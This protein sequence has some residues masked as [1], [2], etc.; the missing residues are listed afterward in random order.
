MKVHVLLENK[1][2]MKAYRNV[3][4]MVTHLHEIIEELVTDL[5]VVQEGQGIVSTGNTVFWNQELFTFITRLHDLLE[6]F[7]A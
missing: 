1:D 6:F 2:R 3:G 7:L 5:W 4:T